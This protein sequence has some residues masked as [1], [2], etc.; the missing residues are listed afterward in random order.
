MHRVALAL[1]ILALLVGCHGSS[2]SSEQPSEGSSAQGAP[3]AVLSLLS[4]PVDG[5]SV[6]AAPLLFPACGKLDGAIDHGTLTATSATTSTSAATTDTATSPRRY[7]VTASRQ[8]HR[9][10]VEGRA[11]HLLHLVVQQQ[12]VDIVLSLLDARGQPVLRVDSLY[13]D[14]GDEE[15][16]WISPETGPL[17]LLICAPRELPQKGSFSAYIKKQAPPSDEERRIAEAFLLYHS[18]EASR[19]RGTEASRLEAID[20]YE[21]AAEQWKELGRAHEVALCTYGLSRIYTDQQEHMDKAIRYASQA[22]R[23]LQATGDFFLVGSSRHRLGFLHDYLGDR[24]EAIVHYEQALA[25]RKEIGHQAGRLRTATNLAQIYMNTGE[26]SLARDLYEEALILANSLGLRSQIGNISTKLGNYYRRMNDGERA[27][28]RLKLALEIRQEFGDKVDISRTHHSLGMTYL[29]LHEYTKAKSHYLEALSILKNMRMMKDQAAVLS[30]LGI[31]EVEL[32]NHDLALTYHTTALQIS[33]ERDLSQQNSR[34]HLDIG[35]VLGETGRCEKAIEHFEI[36]ASIA[37]KNGDN[38]N[39][40][41]GYQNIA[42]CHQWLGNLEQSVEF[43]RRS[44]DLFEFSRERALSM[45]WTAKYFARKR[46]YYDFL[47]DVLVEMSESRKSSDLLIEA[48]E[49]SEKSKARSLLDAL[50]IKSSKDSANHEKGLLLEVERLS[51]KIN[52]DETQRILGANMPDD[53]NGHRTVESM[54]LL[55][56]YEIAKRRL[57]SKNTNSLTYETLDLPSIRKEIGND[58]TLLEFDIGYRESHLWLVDQ[59]RILH[60]P[61]PKADDLKHLTQVAYRNLSSRA[62]P[63]QT[64]LV[65]D[66]LSTLLFEDVFKEI[67]TRR[68][69]VVKDDHLHYLPLDALPSPIERKNKLGEERSDRRIGDDFELI[70]M[71]SVS[72]LSSIRKMALQGKGAKAGKRIAIVADPVFYIDDP[73]LH[74]NSKLPDPFLPDGNDAQRRSADAFPDSLERLVYSGQEA[75]SI[76]RTAEKMGWSTFLALGATADKQLLTT[77]DLSHFDILHLATHADYNSRQPE[78]AYLAF[79]RFGIQGDVRDSLL[80]AYELHELD[81]QGT[82]VVLSACSGA[83]G[84]EIRGEG[85]V[86]L[87]QGFLQAGASRM[88]VSLWQVDDRA[89]A[90]LMGKFYEFLLVD[91]LD[92]SAALWE[93]KRKIR[94]NPEWAAPYYW[95]GFSLVGDWQA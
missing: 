14:R 67:R 37:K 27:L 88:V 51:E 59:G 11:G 71:P 81:F 4:P 68:V 20:L 45:S 31:V 18:A 69:L 29:S 12:Q 5:P 63:D 60:F 41:A 64:A 78:L 70:S 92:L 56:R 90:A 89:T 38:A 61:L 84:S 54:Q 83:L 93:A 9:L 53:S 94:L 43:A 19:R 58:T 21:Q 39:A 33:E 62:R 74:A 52:Q 17:S 50:A 95:A 34:S 49:V 8:V 72:V 7:A 3:A 55:E 10:N 73:R 35:Y 66:R 13:G 22:M 44:V 48:L 85:L 25:I 77:G 23:E 57:D 76:S 36:G 6:P 87:T 46:Y 80:F 24:K 91:K 42:L 32:G 30:S 47:A 16:F 79:S 2:F 75:E 26:L 65:L 1:G 28:E 86:G 40:A 15:I 82:T